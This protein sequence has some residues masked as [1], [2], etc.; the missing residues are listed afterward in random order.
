MSLFVFRNS[1]LEPFFESGAIFSGYGDISGISE[2]DAYVWFYLLPFETGGRKMQEILNDYRARLQLVQSRIP[3]HHPLYVFTI[4]PLFLLRWENSDFSTMQAVE[5]FNQFLAEWAKADTAVKLFD[6]REFILHYPQT[7]WVD[8]KYYFLSGMQLNPRLARDFREWFAQKAGAVLLRAKKCLVLDL[9]NTLWGGI[10]GEDGPQGIRIGGDYPGNAFAMF[11]ESIRELGRKGVIL[12]VCS[13]NNE[14]DVREVWKNNP[15]MILR[16]EDLAACRINWENKADNIRSMAQ[17]LNIGLDSMVFVDDNP[18]ERE[19]VKQMLPMVEVPDFPTQPYLLPAFFERLLEQYFQA[20]ALTGEDLQKTVQYRAN[21]ERTAFRSGFADMR[22]YIASLQIRMQITEADMYTI[23]RAAQLTRKTNQFNLTTRRYSEQ[24]IIR[25]REQ[26]GHV[27]C[28]KVEDRF[29]DYGITGIAITLK[30]DL[31]T[32][33]IDSFLMSCRI[34]GKGMEQ[35]FLKYVLNALK[36]EGFEQV[37][38]SYIPAA[39]NSQAENFYEQAG[40]K[41]TA[42]SDSQKKYC[43]SLAEVKLDMDI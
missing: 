35:A 7:M 12:A 9:D 23:P 5:E 2:A 16:K 43:L 33:V 31:H 13:K 14:N 28:L 10:V 18:S 41:I 6:F 42:Q 25:F 36:Q 38:A 26:G 30:N 3:A 27:F 1:T 34:L 20:Y 15:S 37:Q 11:Q 21:A 19:L 22:E 39:K 24:D 17:E 40:F 4:H 29:G 32:A 8:W